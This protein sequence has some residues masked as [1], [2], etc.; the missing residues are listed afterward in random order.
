[1][2]DRETVQL[3]NLG[4]EMLGT[5]IRLDCQILG[6]IAECRASLAEENTLFH[7]S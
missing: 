5:M 7:A 3:N 6:T 2:E 4:I 1:M